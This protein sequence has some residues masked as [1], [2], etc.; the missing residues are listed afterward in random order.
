MDG[1]RSTLI[2]NLMSTPGG[3]INRIPE[4]VGA[5]AQYQGSLRAIL[6]LS[7]EPGERTQGGDDPGLVIFGLQGLHE[8]LVVGGRHGLKSRPG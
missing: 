7:N 5:I 8:C 2:R 1:L 6:D 3:V 4:G